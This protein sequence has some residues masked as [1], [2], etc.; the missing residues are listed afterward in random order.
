MILYH[1]ISSHIILYHLILYHIISYYIIS[2]YLISSH[3]TLYYIISY[4]IISYH[5]ISYNNM[6]ISSLPVRHLDECVCIGN[7]LVGYESQSKWGRRTR[8]LPGLRGCDTSQ[9]APWSLRRFRCVS[10][11]CPSH[12]QRR[13][14]TRCHSSEQQ[15]DYRHGADELHSLIRRTQTDQI[16]MSK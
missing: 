9:N 14:G 8:T 4:Y 15:S 7:L 6:F 1:L 16:W 12:S 10:E 13:R 2:Y 5:I 11:G 3:I